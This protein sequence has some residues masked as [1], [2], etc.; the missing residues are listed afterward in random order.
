MRLTPLLAALSVLGAGLAHGQITTS[1]TVTPM[2]PFPLPSPSWTFSATVTGALNVGSPSAVGTLDIKTG[3]APDRLPAV[4]TVTA[5]GTGATTI[6]GPVGSLSTVTVEGAGSSF[7]SLGQINLT[8]GSLTISNDAL[9]TGQSTGSSV[10]LNSLN[11]ST[12]TIS[13]GA[14][15]RGQTQNNFA[16][17][18]M[19]TVTG[20]DL[21]GN[22]STF[23]VT[24]LSLSTSSEFKVEAGGKV[25]VGPLSGGGTQQSTGINTDSML[26]VTGLNSTLS[27]TALIGTTGTLE[28][29]KGGRVKTTGPQTAGGLN[30]LG[31]GGTFVATVDGAG[32]RLDTANSLPIGHANPGG[33]GTLIIQNGA[34]VGT[35]EADNPGR[36]GA[37]GFGNATGRVTVTGNNPAAPSTWTNGTPINGNEIG[38]GVG[39][40]GRGELDIIG[41]A[42]SLPRA[43]SRS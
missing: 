11:A 38:V 31:V 30:S 19:V 2:P 4:L 24:L 21:S 15:F 10:S 36:Q 22:P 23:E 6:N 26:M 25:I 20:T 32:S 43:V 1:G 39:T 9:V 3:P 16:N 18:S 35:A 41:S 27:T 17:S 37:I 29:T 14:T 28:I 12:L 13:G 8:R 7:T 42:R 34:S 5:T 33:D 40:G